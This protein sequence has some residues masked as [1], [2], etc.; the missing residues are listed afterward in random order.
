MTGKN[1]SRFGVS[2]I[3]AAFNEAEN[4]ESVTSESLALLR[5]VTPVYEIIIV[6]DGSTDETG[7]ISDHLAKSHETISAIHHGQNRGF[8]A[9]L[10]TGY[11]NAKYDLVTPL[12]ADGQIPPSEL[13]KFV[14]LIANADM[15]I[16]LRP[17]RPYSGYRKL[18]HVGMAGLTRLLFGRHHPPSAGSCMFKQELFHKV[19]LVSTSG[20]ANTEFPIKVAKHG[21]E[22]A[23]IPIRTV[24]RLSGQ[25][26]VA[27][28]RT[29]CVTIWDMIKTRWTLGL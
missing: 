29:I 17:H 16:G 21:Y 8:G 25:S 9:A 19:R 14:P 20:F 10:I 5:Q 18:L 15:V 7:R 13:R 6:D 2:V 24:P 23:T 27:N 12:P 22:L 26:K 3:I 28:V 1:E 4:L 11:A